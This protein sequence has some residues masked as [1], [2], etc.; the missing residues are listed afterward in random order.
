[1][2]E[3]QGGKKG[4]LV[5]ST[6]ICKAKGKAEVKLRA[7]SGAKLTLRPVLRNKGCGK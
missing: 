5:N 2:L 1:V 3:M 4:L 7:H 6:D